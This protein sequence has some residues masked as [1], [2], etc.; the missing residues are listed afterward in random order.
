M[1]SSRSS[2]RT[3]RRRACG[4]ASRRPRGVC[5]SMSTWFGVTPAERV[6]ERLRRRVLGPLRVRRR[7]ARRQERQRARR[8]R[9]GVPGRRGDH[10][11]AGRVPGHDAARGQG[12]AVDVRRGAQR[13]VR[14]EVDRIARVDA[15]LHEVEEAPR[16]GRLAREPETFL[17][18][19]EQRAHGIE[20]V[21]EL[22]AAAVLLR[23]VRRIVEDDRAGERGV[24]RLRLVAD[25]RRSAPPPA[26]TGRCA[27]RRPHPAAS[28]QPLYETTASGA[29]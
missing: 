22:L 15:G 4:R 26:R 6:V 25:D 2:A 28:S 21:A 12:R 29:S 27:G 19:D 13:V 14:R 9:E 8:A 24:A 5:E 11:I 20:L 3:L 18:R 23:G 1:H 16:L 7:E 10:R 17:R